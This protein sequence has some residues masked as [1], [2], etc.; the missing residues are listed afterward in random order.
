VPVTVTFVP[1][2]MLGVVVPV[3]P[4]ATGNVPV[5]PVVKGRPVALVNVALVGVPSTGVT[6]VGD[7]DKT[8]LP[9][10]VDVVAPVPPPEA[11]STPLE[12]MLSAILDR[13]RGM[14]ILFFLP[15]QDYVATL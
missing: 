1:A 15:N 7:V 10:P 4:L 9:V 11:V 14:L 6:R 8:A 3:P 12:S 13:L 5:T 2:T